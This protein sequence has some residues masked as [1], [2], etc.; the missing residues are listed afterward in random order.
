MTVKADR[1]LYFDG[2]RGIAII[3]VVAIHASN[4]ARFL[5]SGQL[6]FQLPNKYQFA[7]TVS[8]SVPVFIF[9][10]G[11]FLTYLLNWGD[12]ISSR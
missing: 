11:Y 7:A 10:S 6:G 5:P 1:D 4:M 12:K 3:G 2:V 8:G 9:R